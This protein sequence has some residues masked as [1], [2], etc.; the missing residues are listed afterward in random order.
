MEEFKSRKGGW[1]PSITK[2]RSI[3]N[4]QRGCCSLEV[5]PADFLRLSS[6]LGVA[7][8]WRHWDV[9][10]V[11]SI[12]NC[13]IFACLSLG[14]VN[15]HGKKF[16]TAV[17]QRGDTIL[18]LRHFCWHEGNLKHSEGLRRAD[19]SMAHETQ[20]IQSLL[21][22]QVAD[23]APAGSGEARLSRKWKWTK[24][25]WVDIQSAKSRIVCIMCLFCIFRFQHVSYRRDM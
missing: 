19:C 17:E 24:M 25:H 14:S 7:K 13:D 9:C 18:T 21:L 5:M 11:G 4:N 3:C 6:S 8:Q 23:L 10:K 22:C 12:Q 2:S 20:N 1:P 16:G 15:L